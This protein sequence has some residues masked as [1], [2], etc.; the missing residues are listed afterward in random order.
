MRE[1]EGEREIVFLYTRCTKT[2]R[3]CR[4]IRSESS[5]PSRSDRAASRVAAARAAASDDVEIFDDFATADSVVQEI[6]VKAKP[7]AGRATGPSP[8]DLVDAS[9]SLSSSS[10]SSPPPASV[11]SSSD[12]PPPAQDPPKIVKIVDPLLTRHLATKE[13]TPRK[14]RVKRYD[15]VREVVERGKGAKKEKKGEM[16]KE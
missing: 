10:P 9:S 8:L 12:S 6:V 15:E 13:S 2:P 7:G 4:A 1:I 16:G 3:L 5:D 11:P 14:D